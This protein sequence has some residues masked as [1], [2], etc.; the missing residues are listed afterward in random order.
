MDFVLGLPRTQR[1]VDSILVVVD[2]FSKM[3]H[4]LHC[5]KTSNAS[6]VANLFFCEIVRLHG[7][8][9]SITS[10]R[11]VKFLSHFWRTLWKLF[12]TSLK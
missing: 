4:F 11:D 6:Y 2:I 1:G 9:R 10:D 5:K 7:I 3:V 8:P 12:D